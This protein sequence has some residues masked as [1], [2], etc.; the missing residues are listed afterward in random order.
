VP[1]APECQRLPFFTIGHSTRAWDDFTA[2]LNS[3][4][5]EALVDVRTVPRS[6]RNPQ[7]DTTYLAEHLPQAGISYRHMP[8]LG[9]LRKRQRDVDPSVNANWENDSFHNY[10]DYALGEE[11]RAALDELVALGRRIPVAVMCAEAKWWQCHRRIIA[12][13][14]LARGET[15]FHILNADRREPAQMNPAARIGEAK[16]VTYPGA[17]QPSLFG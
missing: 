11:F 2:A 4:G 17:H 9:G 14:L 7:F 15:V 8:A 6:R 5:V 16:T 12:D 13:H 3:A 1:D 10:A